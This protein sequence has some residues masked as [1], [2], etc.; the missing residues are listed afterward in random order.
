[1]VVQSFSLTALNISR[2]PFLFA[3]SSVVLLIKEKNIFFLLYINLNTLISEMKLKCVSYLVVKFHR[4]FC[5]MLDCGS[6]PA[7]INSQIDRSSQTVV[8]CSLSERPACLC[9][10]GRSATR[11]FERTMLG[12]LKRNLS[13]IKKYELIDARRGDSR[14]RVVVDPHNL[15]RQRQQ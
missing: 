2:R 6:P 4:I 11:S 9:S 13:L 12:W 5:K 3:T 7:R 10:I 8:D 14:C 1:M 15:G